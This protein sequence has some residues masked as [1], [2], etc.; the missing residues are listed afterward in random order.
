MRSAGCE[1]WAPRPAKVSLKKCARKMRKAER[2]TREVF[3]I[4]RVLRPEITKKL[5]TIFQ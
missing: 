1:S 5:M 3:G 2:G 4:F